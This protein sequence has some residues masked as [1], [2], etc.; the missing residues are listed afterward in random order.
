M[1]RPQT[2]PHQHA[3][4]GLGTPRVDPHSKEI[5]KTVI[6]RRLESQQKNNSTDVLM[7]AFLGWSVGEKGGGV[8]G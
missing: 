5:Y 4:I 6:Q 3:S 7:E 1:L 2:L 8:R